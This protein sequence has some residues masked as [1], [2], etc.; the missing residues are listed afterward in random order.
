MN[1][2][3]SME[4][5]EKRLN[6][7]D[8]KNKQG[9]KYIGLM[10]LIPINKILGSEWIDLNNSFFIDK[11]ISET[12][13]NKRVDELLD[14]FLRVRQSSIVEKTLIRLKSETK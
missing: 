10:N 6:N 3:E 13:F 1:Y 11:K 8:L 9:E 14:N 7:L 5:V 2:S 4:W 12:E